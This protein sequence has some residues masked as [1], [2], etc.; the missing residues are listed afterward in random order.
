MTQWWTNKALLSFNLFVPFS[1]SHNNQFLITKGYN[2]DTIYYFY[3]YLVRL[4]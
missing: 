2:S 3:N 4:L 1:Q